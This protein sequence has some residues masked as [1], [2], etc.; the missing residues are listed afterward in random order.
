MN[1]ANSGRDRRS[2]IPVTKNGANVPSRA[3]LFVRTDIGDLS[4]I[5]LVALQE[6]DLKASCK[7]SGAYKNEA[8]LS[9]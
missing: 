2:E 7:W 4:S 3:C 9:C 5:R 6:S 8:V 1:T